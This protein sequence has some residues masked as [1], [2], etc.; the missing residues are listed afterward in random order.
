MRLGPFELHE[1]IDRGAVG[2][3]WR[4]V[5]HGS[6]L[7]V[8]VKVLDTSLVDEKLEESFK[9]EVRAVARLDH[10]GV[11]WVFDVGKVEAEAAHA[12]KGLVGAGAPYFA[13][14]YA[15]GGTAREWSPLEWSGLRP[16]L[17]ALLDALAHAHARGVIHRDLKP[18]NVLV[19]GAEDI[20]PGLKLA[21]FG[22]AYAQADR[23]SKAG[24]AAVGTLQYMAP[25][26]IRD[27]PWAVGPWTDLYALGCVAWQMVTGKLPFAGRE[28][29]PLARAQLD[30]HLPLAD[31]PVPPPVREWLRRCLQ[32]D[33][34]ARFACAADAAAELLEVPL[35]A[36]RRA[37]GVVAVGSIEHLPTR[38]VR[39]PPAWGPQTIDLSAVG[40]DA[41]LPPGV[42]LAA[43]IAGWPEPRPGVPAA[44][45][46]PIGDWRR[47][48]AQG[49]SLALLGAGVH[50]WNVRHPPLIGRY[51]E[52]DRL[53]NAL[54]RVETSGRP[55]MVVVRGAAGTGKTFLARWLAERASE[56]GHATALELRG[57]DGDGDAPLRRM[58]HRWFRLAEHRDNGARW[59]ASRLAH[60]R[61]PSATEDIA[62][63]LLPGPAGARRRRSIDL[64]RAVARARPIV[65]LV[66][67]LHR[68]ADLLALAEEALAEDG[69]LPLLVVATV[70]EEDLAASDVAPGLQL[71]LGA[72][73]DRAET[74]ALGPLPAG[75]LVTLVQEFLGLSPALAAQ[76]VERSGGNPQFAISLIGEWVTRGVLVL[77]A[78]GFEVR[79]GVV[80]RLPPWIH[81]AWDA[82]VDQ[83]LAGLPDTAEELL[84]RAAVLGLDVSRGEWAVACDDPDG[85]HAAAGHPLVLENEQ[86]RDELVARLARGRLAAAGDDRF[87]FAHA[88][89][90][91]VI[92]ARGAAAAIGE[93]HLAAAEMLLRLPSSEERDERVGHHLLHAGQEKRALPLLFRAVLPRWDVG[94][95]R[96]ALGLL[97][98]VEEALVSLGLPDDDPRWVELWQRRAALYAEL[99]ELDEA[100]RAA[101]W[102]LGAG[103]EGR[104]AAPLI[105]AEITLGRVFA[106]RGDLDG[107]DACWAAAAERQ[108]DNQV[109]RGIVSAERALVAARRGDGERARAL[110]NDAIRC[111]RRDA[112]ARALAECW[113]VVA[114]T[115]TVS[116]DD[117]Q[118][119]EA[120]ERALRLFEQRGHLT[121]QAECRAGLGRIA[122]RAGRWPA[123]SSLLEEAIAQYELG[124][125]GDAVTPR[126]DLARVR[127]AQRRLDDAR[128]IVHHLRLIGL[129]RGR[130]DLAEELVELSRATNDRALEA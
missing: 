112:S 38:V 121:G 65:L 18:A 35:S 67:E 117:E 53:W 72:L 55:A 6:R 92:L 83:V 98:R 126:V 123:A 108:T 113:R 41:G 125:D 68:S 73:G 21:D 99:G 122:I 104:D 15:S 37:V 28:G 59:V 91:E 130:T 105:E 32:K 82:R 3:V 85:T 20:R 34:D 103:G 116:G 8:A 109:L 114:R 45:G 127:I 23:R 26:Q 4:A 118:A 80:A 61:L 107:A 57:A 36:G 14:E 87:A 64:L 27:E 77:G 63:L 100:E 43:E 84:V 31:L 60:Y 11:V 86:L 24:R 58:W 9:Y 13:M 56:L 17:L 101:W 33:P 75:D 74:V 69:P 62:T 71:L 44:P 79:S 42:E 81:Q 49:R 2:V 54:R 96:A 120:W 30:E 39:E 29:A 19:C 47:P 48:E 128:E 106:A 22:I 12:S 51:A 46:R 93:H 111:V 52:R 25:E 124:G 7:P 102:V 90:R 70:R 119:R 76:V 97:A 129:R 10:P 95:P 94:G 115:A 66:D 89:V 16:V 78:S 110:T 88:M 50:M 1:A 40:P 5:H